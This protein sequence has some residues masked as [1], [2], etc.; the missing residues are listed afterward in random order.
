[1]DKLARTESSPRRTTREE[2]PVHPC[3][4]DLVFSLATC[5]SLF[6]LG[7]WSL[8]AA[9]C[10]AQAKT[11]EQRMS[12][13][14]NLNPVTPEQI[15]AKEAAK[16]AAMFKSK[17]GTT[18]KQPTSAAPATLT[19]ATA[20]K[21]QPA[22]VALTPILDDNCNPIAENA[23]TILAHHPNTY[24]N[25]TK[26]VPNTTAPT[27]TAYATA[28]L[29]EQDNNGFLIASSFTKEK[30]YMPNG[31]VA[32]RSWSNSP[33]SSTNGTNGS[34]NG[35][36]WNGNA[37][38]GSTGSA[39]IARTTSPTNTVATNTTTKFGTSS[40][41]STTNSSTTNGNTGNTSELSQLLANAFAANSEGTMDPMRVWFIYASLAV[42][43]P[44]I[45]LP[46]GWSNDLVPA[47]RDRVLAAH[48]GFA[49][50]G[51]SF[52]DGATNV[53]SATR[54]AL[55]AALT[56]EPAL[57]IPR[58]DL[59]S[60]V[61]GYGDYSPIGRRNFLQ[62]SNNRVIVYSELDGFRSNLENGK[63]TTRLAT[64]VSIVASNGNNSAWCRTPEWTEVVDTADNRRNEF[65][66]GE[67]I[68]I[69]ANLAM[70]N[71]FVKV[72]VKD[73]ATGATTSSIVPFKVLDKQ[74][75]AAAGDNGETN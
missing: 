29:P 38:T 45:K 25:K 24:L 36:S 40:N 35:N 18:T 22:V 67:I 17:P 74:A 49:A 3:T 52:R 42:S 57:T 28:P 65:F 63:W 34:W 39:T 58:V 43:N 1:M 4:R 71:Y 47:E 56:G 31:M 30:Y 48:A 64:R 54:Q 10:S 8:T 14:R 59:C 37:W 62:G 9:G 66:L 61:V 11:N 44:D 69:N 33:W 26:T 75:F 46:E 53:D 2:R 20:T 32:L 73:L 13:R 70:G 50:L 72:E 27:L 19:A 41:S 7:S 60:K 21:T 23:D 5:G 51:K 6:V 12:Q 55:V 15:A 68:P 16:N